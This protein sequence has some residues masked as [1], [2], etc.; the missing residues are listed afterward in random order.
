LFEFNE[1]MVLFVLDLVSILGVEPPGFSFPKVLAAASLRVPP[2]AFGSELIFQPT[3]ALRRSILV[4]FFAQRRSQICFWARE[5]GARIHHRFP[6][7]GLRLAL[8][9]P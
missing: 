2:L 3:G 9:A 1:K 7:E 8:C 6:R 4:N 5:P